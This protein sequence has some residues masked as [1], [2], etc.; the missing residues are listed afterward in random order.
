MIQ[1]N[2]F[3]QS[4]TNNGSRE[5]LSNM[6]WTNG[7]VAKFVNAEEAD[8]N[9]NK[10]VRVE[11]ADGSFV[12]ANALLR[13][14]NG[15]DY[16]TDKLEDAAKK[17]FAAISSGEGLTLTFKKVFKADNNSGGKTTYYRFNDKKL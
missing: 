6:P 10:F 16:Q 7:D 8:V 3:I 12:S 11:T 9:G 14:G 13:R 5:S 4:V 2:S 17:L 15:I 1:E